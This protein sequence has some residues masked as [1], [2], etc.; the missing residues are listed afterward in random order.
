MIFASDL[1]RTLIYSDK[2]TRNFSGQVV[3]V[4][5]G[6][7]SSYMTK[8][9]AALLK[10]IAGKAFFV[11]CTTRTIEQYLRIGFFQSE[12]VPKYAIV[13]NGANLLVDGAVDIT[14]HN[15]VLQTLQRECLAGQDI[16]TEFSRLEAGE[17]AQP[18]RNADGVFYYCLIDRSKTPLTE[19]AAFS[20]WARD[21]KWVVS[22]QGRKLY[23]TPEVINKWVAL[24]KVSELTGDD[25]VVAC[26]DSLLDLPLIRGA[27]L[28][29]SPAHGELFEQFGDAPARLQGNWL[30]TAASGILAGEELLKTIQEESGV[31]SQ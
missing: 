8:T 28:A 19:L 17:W 3:A 2:F 29:L 31:R 14:Y 24:R 6:K 23:L 21:Q 7:Y 22:I 10:S 25:Y 18:M 12:V 13:S 4:E 11:P 26:G 15:D 1:D 20:N 16:L 5:T 9:A 30:F 27:D